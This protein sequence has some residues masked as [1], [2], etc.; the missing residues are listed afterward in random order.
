MEGKEKIVIGIL[1]EWHLMLCSF[2][3]D[4]SFSDAGSVRRASSYASERFDVKAN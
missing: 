4:G 1:G 2:E 3:V